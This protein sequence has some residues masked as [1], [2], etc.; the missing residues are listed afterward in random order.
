M[1]RMVAAGQ[2]TARQLRW[3]AVAEGFD[4]VSPNP[5]T[6]SVFIV[7]AHWQRRPFRGRA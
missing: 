7:P 5:G 3:L 2:I 1:I 6:G 4:N